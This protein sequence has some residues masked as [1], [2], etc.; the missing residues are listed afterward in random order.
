MRKFLIAITLLLLTAL[1]IKAE[2]KAS[3][4]IDS[5]TKYQHVTGFGG[6]GPSPQWAYWLTNA[7]IDKMYGTGEDQL[8]YNIMRLYIANNRNGWSSAI[9]TAKRAK[10][11]GA[12]LF[13]SPWSPPASWK[14]NNDDSNGG[15]LL[16]E[17]YD[18][19][20]YFLNDFVTYMKNSGGVT[21]DA[22]SIQNEPDW[23]ASYQSCLW[24]GNQFVTFLKKY[25]SKINAKIIAPEGIQF[26]HSLSDPILNDPEACAEL[27]ILGGHF[28]G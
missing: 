21:I 19:W 4:S 7:E 6:F 23:K 8:G 11:H 18:D 10:K 27:D 17:Y 16:T 22:I 2:V 5:R 15:S 28:Y 13:A 20:A 14:D 3:I 12:F 24:T 25:G 26:T 1:E 9:N